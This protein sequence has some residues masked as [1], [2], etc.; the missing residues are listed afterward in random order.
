MGQVNVTD[1]FSLTNGADVAEQ[2]DEADVTAIASPGGARRTTRSPWTRS[3]SPRPKWVDWFSPQTLYE[4]DGDMPAAEMDAA[5][6]HSADG[7]GER[8]ILK[9]ETRTRRGDPVEKGRLGIATP[10]ASI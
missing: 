7:A 9:Q 5:H 1:P 10:G 2:F 8:R 3:R 6:L 4:N